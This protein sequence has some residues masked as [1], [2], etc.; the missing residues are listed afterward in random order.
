MKKVLLPHLGMRIVIEINKGHFLWLDSFG[1][2]DC[3]PAE[4]VIVEQQ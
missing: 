3:T 2:H 1:W 4:D